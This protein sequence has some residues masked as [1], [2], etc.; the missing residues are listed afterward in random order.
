MT[1][2]SLGRWS[3]GSCLFVASV[4]LALCPL[5]HASLAREKE[6]KPDKAERRRLKAIQKEMQSPYKKWL[7]EEVP[8][9]ISPEER[10]AF[11]KL[12]TDEEREQFI[13]SFWERRNPDPGSSEN[14]FKEEYYRRI[15]YA[16]EHYSSGVPGWKTDRGRIYIMYGPP[17]EIDPHPSG[18]TYDRPPEEGGGTTSTYPFEQWRYRYIENIGENVVLEF[19]DTSM[20]GEYHLA[21]DPGEKDALSHVPGIG[22]TQ[23]EAMNMASKRDRFT[24]T[25]GT[26]LGQPLGM[27]EDEFTRLDRYYRIFKGPD[28]KY[29]DLKALV[30]SRLS[31]HLLPF[32]VREDFIR[33]TEESVLMPVTLQV[34]NRDL[35]FVDNSGVMHATLDIFGQITS[36]GGRIVSR[37]QDSVALDV[38]KGEFQRFGNLT[39]AYQKSIPLRPG[40]YKL[41]VVVK[42]TQSGRAGSLEVGTRVPLYL[43]DQLSSSSLILADVVQPLPSRQ[44][45]SGP[46]VIGGMKVRP[47]VTRIF[48]RNQNLG[49]YL[50][51][52]NLGIDPETHQP[53]VEVHYDIVK[54]GTTIVSKDQ[55]T[56]QVKAASQQIILA[57]TLPL[58]SLQ[59][60]KYTVA[61]RVKDNVR[62][63]TVTP[64][65]T[66]ELR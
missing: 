6:A 19:V 45:G 33:V 51:V 25:D 15:A 38:P 26:T 65:E 8:Y 50:Q 21:Y 28:V 20:T 5:G 40:L 48:T 56:A 63:Q 53:S 30:T 9:I 23:L 46:F 31:A 7:E 49:L 1:R 58:K 2:K 39:S 66:F 61:I 3:I 59:P 47:S 11:N 32:D 24:N 62:K 55:K 14:E 22:L 36:L 64:S 44:V 54:D 37:F 29:N 42:D 60:G 34:A 12:S 4:G 16:N 13:E 10:A 52:Y 27:R 18:G 35:E 17:D 41:T 57:E 43:D